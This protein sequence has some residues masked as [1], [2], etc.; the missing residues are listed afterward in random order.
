M[1]SGYRVLIT[2]P[3][4][5]VML[6]RY[7]CYAVDVITVTGGMAVEWMIITELF[8]FSPAVL[9]VI[10]VSRCVGDV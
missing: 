7:C 2:M 1:V 3:S 9:L 5:T 10:H 8:M 6:S 4:I